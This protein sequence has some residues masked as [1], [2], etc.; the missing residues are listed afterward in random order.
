MREDENCVDE[1]GEWTRVLPSLSSRVSS[2][3]WLCSRESREREDE[4]GWDERR[5]A[6]WPH[7]RRHA[8][9]KELAGHSS[10]YTQLRATHPSNSRA[11]PRSRPLVLL[12]HPHRRQLAPTMPREPDPSINE[13]EFVHKCLRKG[14][15]LDGRGMYDLRDV[16]LRFGDELGWVECRLGDTRCAR[17]SPP[18]QQLYRRTSPAPRS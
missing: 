2:C 16:Q 5:R 8:R 4:Q 1:R 18:S 11:F 17:P 14:V 9:R 15:R 7:L 6:S 3:R 12:A 13:A 10:E